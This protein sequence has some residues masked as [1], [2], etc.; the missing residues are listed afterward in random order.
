MAKI[1]GIILDVDGTLWDAVA[2]IH[3]SW[4]DEVREQGYQ[5]DFT[6]DQI[7]SLCGLRMEGFGDALFSDLSKEDRLR[8]AYDCSDH[9]L[10]RMRKNQSMQVYQ[11]VKDTLAVLSREYPLY[12]VTNAEDGYAQL[13]MEFSETENYITAYAHA[14]VDRTKADNIRNI[15]Q[16]N[17]LKNPVYVGDAPTDE[18][19]SVNAGATFIW[20][21]YGFFEGLDCQHKIQEFTQLPAYLKS[22]E[23]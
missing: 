23:E 2:A 18:T 12:I 1:D 7:R 15:I 21:E 11:G 13:F 6:E 17:A 4:I 9:Q 8:L 10:D 16:E 19:A 22:M 3:Q 20:A 5:Y 14:A